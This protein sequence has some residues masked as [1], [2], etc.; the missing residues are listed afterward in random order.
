[1]RPKGVS[2]LPIPKSQ[3][4]GVYWDRTWERWSAEISH[5]SKAIR[6]G[7]FDKEEDAAE[8]IRLAKLF[9]AGGGNPEALKST[10][11]KAI[12]RERQKRRTRMLQTRWMRQQRRRLKREQA[13]GAMQ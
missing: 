5:Q 4:R 9:L 10:R 2:A 1:M 6:L 8:A 3:T 12:R 13:S 7:R 11:L